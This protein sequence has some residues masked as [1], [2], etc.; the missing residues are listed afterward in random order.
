MITG[1]AVRGFKSL[2]HFKIGGLTEFTC[3]VGLNGAGKS[4]VLQFLDFAAHLMRG[5]VNHWLIKRGWNVSELHSKLRTKSNIVFAIQVSVASGESYIWGASFNRVTCSCTTEQFTRVSDKEIVFSLAKGRYSIGGGSPNKLDFNYTGSVLSSLKQEMLP[6]D[7]IDAKNQIAS[8]RSLELLSPHLM[9]TAWR[10]AAGDIGV[11]GEKLSPFLYSIKGVERDNLLVLLR[12]FYPAVVD[13]KIKHER[14]GWKKLYIIEEFDGV[15]V[16]TESKHVNDGLLR[17]L[18]IIAQSSHG[19]SLLLF[20]EIENGVNPEVVELLVQSLAE[21][22]QQV[23]VTTHSPM[24]LNYLSDDVARNSVR[25]VY[26]SFDGGTRS[27]PLFASPKMKDKLS[28][29]GPGEAFVDTSLT[30]LAQEFSESDKAL[31]PVE[32]KDLVSS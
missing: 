6:A 12:K 31:A 2:A 9:R 1:F 18:A 8:M 16:E 14:A 26:R 21:T 22:K 28:I 24:I 3:L 4:S 13:F 32:S 5:D 29:M 20:D 17:I 15:R 25:F 7:I 27:R 10:D 19:D 11:G 23:I 30:Q